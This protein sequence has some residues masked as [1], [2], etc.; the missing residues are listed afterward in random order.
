MDDTRQGSFLNHTPNRR[1]HRTCNLFRLGGGLCRIRIFLTKGFNAFLH[2]VHFGLVFGFPIM[3]VFESVHRF[4]NGRG[5]DFG[6]LHRLVE[7]MGRLLL[8][9]EGRL[10]GRGGVGEAFSEVIFVDGR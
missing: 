6:A 4:C 7:G 5:V 8:F 3:N 9:R 10:D 1:F 2:L